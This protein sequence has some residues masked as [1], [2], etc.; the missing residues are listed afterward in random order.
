MGKTLLTALMLA[1]SAGIGAPAFA[2]VPAPSAFAQAPADKPASAQAPPDKPVSEAPLPPG[3]VTRGAC[4]QPL[5]A[6]SVTPPPDTTFI[7]TWELCFPS[8]ATP[9][10]PNGLT[11]IEPE[12]YLFYVKFD[13]LISRPRDGIWSP[14]NE[15]AE[16]VAIADFRR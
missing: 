12:T 14:W 11:S 1:V 8:Q 4:G 15:A 10:A 16:E 9:E 7:W 5:A 3:A 6:P 2:Q 13:E